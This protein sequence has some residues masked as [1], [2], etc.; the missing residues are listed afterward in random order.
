M[1]GKKERKE[2]K[3]KKESPLLRGLKMNCNAQA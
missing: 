1:P 3:K 2:K